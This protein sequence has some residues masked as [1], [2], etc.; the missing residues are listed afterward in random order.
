MLGLAAGLGVTGAFLVVFGWTMSG[1]PREVRKTATARLLARILATLANR[2][3]FSLALWV[4]L[5]LGCAEWFVW[6]LAL[7]G[8]AYW[9]AWILSYG[10]PPTPLLLNLV[11]QCDRDRNSG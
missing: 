10:A 6:V 8:N 1:R 11:P 2:D 3:G 7:G 9:V 4:T 5:L